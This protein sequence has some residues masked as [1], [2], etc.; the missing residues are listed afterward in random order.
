MRRDVAARCALQDAFADFA[1][2]GAGN[3]W[4]KLL[5]WFQTSTD[6]LVQSV[7]NANASAGEKLTR[8]RVPGVRC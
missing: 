7:T 5:H 2:G 8:V 6:M 1:D 3:A 4:I